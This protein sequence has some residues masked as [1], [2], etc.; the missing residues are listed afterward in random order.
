MKSYL[1]DCRTCQ[2][3]SSDCGE[4]LMSFMAAPEYGGPIQF[5]QEEKDALS[6]MADAG[7]IPR[8]RLVTA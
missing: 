1:I 7:L 2:A 6:L 8:L 5:S 4:C 3:E